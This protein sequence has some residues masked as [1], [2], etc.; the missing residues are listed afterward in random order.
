[1][2]PKEME[3]FVDISMNL[4]ETLTGERGRIGEG[5]LVFGKTNFLEYTGIVNVS[6]HSH[7]CVCLTMTAEMIR[8][9]LDSS[10]EESDGEEVRQDFVGEAASIIASNARKTFGA[11]FNIA[12]PSR[13]TSEMWNQLELPYSRFTLPIEWRRHAAFLFLAIE[14]YP[15]PPCI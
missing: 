5:R 1:M 12:T 7:G 9:M 3:T 11:T 6:G 10:G 14:E 8:E 13:L 15:T 2:T 4:L